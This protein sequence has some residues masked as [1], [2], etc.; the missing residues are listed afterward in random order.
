MNDMTAPEVTVAG[1][2]VT[3][4]LP[5]SYAE[6]WE[7]GTQTTGSPTRATAACL[8]SCWPRGVPWPGKHRPTL[9]GCGYDSMAYGG[10]V[11]DSLIAS[12]AKMAEIAFAGTLAYGLV[13]HELYGEEEVSEA[14]DFSDPPKGA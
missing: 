5:H 3:L 14:E 7:L 6:R 10:A 2:E 8:G 4:S 9:S 13:T 12:G 1:V 11:I